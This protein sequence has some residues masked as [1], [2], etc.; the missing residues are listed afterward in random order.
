MTQPVEDES[1]SGPPRSG[2]TM[3]YAELARD[4]TGA[5]E[6]V[7]LFCVVIDLGDLQRSN[8]VPRLLGP[9][10]TD[11]LVDA[12]EAR[13]RD[14]VASEVRLHRVDSGCF[15]FVLADDGTAAW[16]SMLDRLIAALRLP[17]DC[18]GLP[19]AVE[20]CA[21]VVRTH[22]GSAKAEPVL[23]AAMAAAQDARAADVGWRL[24]ESDAEGAYH[25]TRA[26]LAGLPQALA[27]TD[28][29]SLAYQPRL[30]FQSGACLGA[31]AL[32][33][34]NHPTLGLV[35]PGDFIPLSEQSGMARFIT[36]WVVNRALGDLADWTAA[37][38]GFGVSINVS[39]INLA[40]ENFARRIAEAIRQSG[41]DPALVELE[42]TEGAFVRD[43]P[44]VRGTVA[45][46]AAIGVGISIDDFGTG[47][48][49][50]QYLRDIPANVL[51]IDQSFVRSL[52]V[53]ARDGVIVRSMIDLAH[54]L[55]YRVVAEGIEDV[56]AMTLL[57]DWNCD[58][59]QGYF[60]AWPAPVAAMKA[61]VAARSRED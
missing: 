37:G 25:R 58:E 17:F 11:S 23:R 14:I 61:W 28:Q 32:L 21:G 10:Y 47:Y 57:A 51:K 49:N 33:R 35:P 30:A 46:L 9:E 48:S 34:W 1:D 53:N 24:Q 19:G 3:S 18:A 12:A 41:V 40:E 31:E 59:G 29:L 54:A 45:D 50:L 43:S 42:F 26:L 60:I 52:G 16:Q 38:F 8:R 44:R 27:A 15:A 13:I 56:E 55:G 7:P 4:V 36:T 5:P 22:A 6:A 20:P 2:R 39:A